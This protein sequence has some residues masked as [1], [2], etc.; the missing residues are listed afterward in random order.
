MRKELDKK[1]KEELAKKV[2]EQYA[3]KIDLALGYHLKDEKEG[4]KIFLYTGERMPAVPPAWVGLHFGTLVEGQFC[5][6]IEG[7]MLM[8]EASKNVI[9]VGRKEMEELMKGGE[10]EDKAGLKGYVIARTGEMACPVVAREGRLASM[11]PKS[12]R[13]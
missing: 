3:F 9:Q 13:I 6:S 7:A 1:E 5:P 10:I 12:R 11:T 2:E 4:Q 8:K